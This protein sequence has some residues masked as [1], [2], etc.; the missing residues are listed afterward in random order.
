MT[1]AEH[2]QFLTALK[3]LEGF[4]VLSGYDC[5]LYREAL[6]DWSLVSSE[7]PAS[8]NKGT[9][10]RTECLWLSPRVAELSRQ[11]DMFAFGGAP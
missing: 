1:D 4:V 6:Q 8:G 5:E 3:N 10:Y 7:V 11:S 2:E 9:V